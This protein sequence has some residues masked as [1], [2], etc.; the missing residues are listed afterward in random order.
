[1]KTQTWVIRPGKDIGAGTIF[2]TWADLRQYAQQD[3]KYAMQ[4]THVFS[5]TPCQHLLDIVK[6][7]HLSSFPC[8]SPS[9]Y[10]RMHYFYYDKNIRCSNCDHIVGY[11]TSNI[12]EY[13]MDHLEPKRVAERLADL[14]KKAVTPTIITIKSTTKVEPGTCWAKVVKDALRKIESPEPIPKDMGECD[15]S[16]LFVCLKKC[17]RSIVTLPTSAIGQTFCHIDF[18]LINDCY[19][20]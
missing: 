18:T 6:K 14:K 4:Y 16:D 2:D 11:D 15:G 8:P 7:P 5:W 12:Y 13:L 9:N 20:D 10:L 1:M 19:T 3:K 17:S